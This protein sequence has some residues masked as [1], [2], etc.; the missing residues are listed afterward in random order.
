MKDA[1]RDKYRIVLGVNNAAEIE[2]YKNAETLLLLSGSSLA[3]YLTGKLVGY[4]KRH[5]HKT[6]DIDLVD[7][8]T[9]IW[10]VNAEKHGFEIYRQLLWLARKKW[11]LGVDY[12]ECQHGKKKEYRYDYDRCLEK[13]VL[14]YGKKEE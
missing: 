2:T 3:D 6:D 8:E 7:S 11:E 13:L 12:W 9:L 4:L 5:G 14:A 1:S 10:R